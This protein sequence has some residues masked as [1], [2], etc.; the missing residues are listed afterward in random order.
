MSEDTYAKLKKH[1][2]NKSINVL[3]DRND[4]PI[5]LVRNEMVPLR[6]SIHISSGRIARRSDIDKKFSKIK[7]A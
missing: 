2:Q 4:L 1:L 3:D 5:G 6:G 7:F